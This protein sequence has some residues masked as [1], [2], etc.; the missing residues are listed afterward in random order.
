MKCELIN[1]T[2]NTWGSDMI[3]YMFNERDH[4][5][6]LTMPIQSHDH[7][8]RLIWKASKDGKYSVKSAYFSS[9]GKPH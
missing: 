3:Q 4:Q 5:L 8:D 1:T 6:I 7:E 2:S 9:H